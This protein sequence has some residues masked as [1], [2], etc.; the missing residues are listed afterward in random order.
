MWA[1]RVRAWAE[2]VGFVMKNFHCRVQWHPALQLPEEN[3]MEEQTAHS[4]SED[5]FKKNI[6]EFNEIEICTVYSGKIGAD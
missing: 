3:P 5:K 2:V 4:L 1:N 6:A